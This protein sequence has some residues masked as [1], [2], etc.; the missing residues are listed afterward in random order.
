M[1]LGNNGN[2]VFAK[3]LCGRWLLGFL[4]V[5]KECQ[6][7]VAGY[8]PDCIFDIYYLLA[9]IICLSLNH[10]MFYKERCV[11]VQC[12][13]CSSILTISVALSMHNVCMPITCHMHT[14]RKDQEKSH[15]YLNQIKP[16]H[17]TGKLGLMLGGLLHILTHFICYFSL[18]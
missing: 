12:S 3:I 15:I 11:Y 18:L 5:R 2:T 6:V 16:H 1:F 10:K 14:W 13:R 4:R 9:F 8:S 17:L 7:W